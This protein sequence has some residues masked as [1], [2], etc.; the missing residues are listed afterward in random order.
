MTH[1]ATGTPIPGNWAEHERRER[2]DGTRPS[3]AETH[4][5]T[6]A[7]TREHDFA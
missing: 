4:P 2:G 6:T 5:A 1:R 3:R 7:S